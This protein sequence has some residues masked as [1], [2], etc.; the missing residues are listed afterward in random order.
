MFCMN[1]QFVILLKFS[2]HN[3]YYG[4]QQVCVLG[5]KSPELDFGREYHSPLYW[6]SAGFCVILSN[7]DEDERVNRSHRSVAYIKSGELY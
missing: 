1:I 7:Q 4:N 6:L 5:P 3:R 2:C